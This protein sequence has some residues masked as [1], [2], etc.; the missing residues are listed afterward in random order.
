VTPL[1]ADLAPLRRECA[2]RLCRPG[3][4]AVFDDRLVREN[5]RGLTL[6][7]LVLQRMDVSD[8]PVNGTE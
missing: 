8:E 3:R 5:R 4:E 6:D 7:G 2:A 1:E